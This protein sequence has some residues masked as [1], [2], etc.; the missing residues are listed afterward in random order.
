MARF[1]K[2][3]ASTAEEAKRIAA[4]AHRDAGSI[5]LLFNR[6]GGLQILPPGRDTEWKYVRPL[7][8]HAIVNLGDA[9]VTFTNGLFRSNPHRVVAPPGQQAGHTKISLVYFMRPENEVIM[10]RLKGSEL[11]PDLDGESEE[12]GMTAEEWVAHRFAAIRDGKGM[13]TVSSTR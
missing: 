9:M 6:L 10:Q 13:K 1:I 12:Q 11:I 8:G 7:P 4:P 5:T 3:E 2:Y